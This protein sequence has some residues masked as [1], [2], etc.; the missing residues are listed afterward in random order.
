MYTYEY[1]ILCIW[2][3]LVESLMSIT[4]FSCSLMEGFRFLFF[5][6]LFKGRHSSSVIKDERREGLTMGKIIFKMISFFLCFLL[7]EL[8][9]KE[10]AQQHRLFCVYLKCASSRLTFKSS[11]LLSTFDECLAFEVA[12]RI[13]RNSEKNIRESSQKKSCEKK[14]ITGRGLTAVGRIENTCWRRRRRNISI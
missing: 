5:K 10:T 3:T 13:K 4:V 7:G 6:L 2:Y 1:N 14:G 12:H 11:L 9:W 8:K